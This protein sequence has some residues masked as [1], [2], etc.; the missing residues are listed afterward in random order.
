MGKAPTT[1]C[2]HCFSE[3]IVKNGHHHGGKLQFL[4]RSCNKHFTEETALGYPSTNIPFPAIAYLLYFRR[5]VPSFSNMRNYRRFVNYWLVYLR[6]SKS[7]VSRQTIH[8]WIKNFDP[9][10]DSVVSFDDS[11]K[12]V[13]S[14]LE[15]L[16]GMRP[17][18]RVVSYSCSLRFLEG[19]FGKKFLVPLLKSDEAFFRELVNVVG[20]HGV[21]CWEFDDKKDVYGLR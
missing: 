15:Q 16:T 2:P 21:F 6:V 8:H 1:R 18:A 4:C 5:K 14:R 20:K 10:L 17:S 12:Y 19:K 7:D 13:H 3:I 11:K 9:L